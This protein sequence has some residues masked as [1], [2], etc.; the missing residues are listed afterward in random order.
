M[1][2]GQL[3]F[4]A[5][6][7]CEFLS[8]DILYTRYENII[9]LRLLCHGVDGV[10]TPA[11]YRRDFRTR[12]TISTIIMETMRICNLCMF[13]CLYVYTT[14]YILYSFNTDNITDTLVYVCMYV[15]MYVCFAAQRFSAELRR[16]D[17]RLSN[18]V[19]MGE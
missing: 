13:V 9:L 12:L 10:F 17:S 3:G 8:I 7:R 1:N 5:I 18:I 19:F 11:D 2:D 14:R 16:N 6:R 15:C 4:D